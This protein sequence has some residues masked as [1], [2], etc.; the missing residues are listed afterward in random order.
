VDVPRYGAR[1]YL[2]IVRGLRGDVRDVG[3]SMGQAQYLIAVASGT[4]QMHA[5][6]VLLA[7]SGE[8]PAHILHVRPPRFVSKDHP[9]VSGVDLT[10]PDF[11]LVRAD[12]CAAEAQDTAQPA[13]SEAVQ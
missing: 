13:V 7:A 1:G 4:P 9:L 8:I 11:P 5:C 3:Q 10:S 2:A 6:W 12:V